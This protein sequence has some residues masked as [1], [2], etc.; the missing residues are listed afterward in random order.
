MASSLLAKSLFDALDI[1][2]LGP[3]NHALF[4][5]H[6]IH[7]RARHAS[8]IL[9]AVEGIILDG[10]GWIV[11]HIGQASFEL[12]DHFV[13]VIVDCAPQAVDLLLVLKEAL[14][15][16]VPLEVVYLEVGLPVLFGALVELL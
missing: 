1:R 13:E 14:A 10:L 2:P 4:D 16:Y 12:A 9:C 7:S 6:S 11:D 3:A 15:E 5:L 8:P